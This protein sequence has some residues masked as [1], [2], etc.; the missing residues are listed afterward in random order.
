M[1]EEKK[2]IFKLPFSGKI[3][4]KAHI[5]AEHT[6]KSNVNIN[7]DHTSKKTEVGKNLADVL[8]HQ[9]D[10]NVKISTNHEKHETARKALDVLEK[11]NSNLPSKQ[12]QES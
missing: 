6:L 9:S 2:G 7:F 5:G 4:A 10:N 11:I 8:K 1:S 3:E 12:R